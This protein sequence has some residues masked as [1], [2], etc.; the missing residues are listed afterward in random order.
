MKKYL[1]IVAI[2]VFLLSCTDMERDNEYDMH[3]VNY[4]GD[5][6]GES[7]SSSTGTSN[8]PSSSS[9]G[10]SSS[11]SGGSLPQT[12]NAIILTLTYWRTIDTDIGGLDPKIYF[13]VI[14]HQNG[15]IISNNNSDV[16]LN[17]EDISATW[18]GSKKSSPVPFASQSDSLVIKAVVIEKDVFSDDDISP[19]YYTYWKPVPSAGR[20]GST[21]LDYGSGKSTV[22]FNYEFIRQ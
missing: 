8:N 19:G 10:T 17:A 5:N 20:S 16:L 3:A 12:A 18:T 14:A 11:S 21:T 2:S 1:G 13:K 9:N 6:S 22:R 4:I 7:S 15:R